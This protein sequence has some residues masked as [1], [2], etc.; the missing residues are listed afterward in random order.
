MS[1]SEAELGPS[2]MRLHA[3]LVLQHEIVGR[4]TSFP[5]IQ[6]PKHIGKLCA[7]VSPQIPFD[8]SDASP[9]SASNFHLSDR[10]HPAPGQSVQSAQ[11]HQL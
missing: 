8:L 4:N 5:V 7:T 2:R 11:L 6:E 1:L 9:P 10:P 3:D